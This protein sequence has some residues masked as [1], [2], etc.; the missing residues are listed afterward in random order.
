MKLNLRNYARIAEAAVTRKVPVYAHFGI[1]HRCNLTCKMCG[2]W[3][4]GN[5]KEELDISEIQRMAARMKRLG[6]VQVSIG[7]GE[8]FAYSNLEEAAKAF[9]DEGLNVRVLT[10]GVDVPYERLDK[11]IEYGVKNFSI[12][13]DSLYPQ[14]FDYI[15]EHEGS[16]EKAVSTMVYLSERV[17]D[18]G[19]IL[20]MNTVVSNLNLEE[21]P[22]LVNFARE[23]GFA[24]SFL[25][26]ELLATSKD[27]VR[28]WEA[29]FIR[30]RP[31]MGLAA[32]PQSNV[33]ERIDRSYDAL[34]KMKKDG[35]NILNSTPYLNLART[36]LKTGRFPADGC[37][38]GALYFSISPNG[39]F[40]ICHRTSHG[41]KHFLDDDFEEYFKSVE[42]E[43][44]RK[45]EAAA[46]EGCMRACWIDTSSI[47]R[48][49]E[50]FLEMSALN[51]RP[52]LRKPCSI[53]EAMAWAKYDDV[54]VVPG[55]AAG[56]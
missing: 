48:T 39:Q 22:D 50:G 55:Q 43:F 44:K 42:Y 46:C 30:H 52:Q 6:V 27:G 33:A 7:G 10:N 36:Y 24:V 23:I 45:M 28:N 9:I 38:A 20:I 16:W 4:Y 1:T 17:W 2:I 5:E 19:G 14:R 15:C 32:G 49:M 53:E 11:C 26:V 25:P 12:S 37:D 41:Y 18:K 34:I 54:D 8:P 35:A 21:A 31:E 47:F 51:L 3:R 29:R 40:T 13:L 56:K